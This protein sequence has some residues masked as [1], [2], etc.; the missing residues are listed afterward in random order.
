MGRQTRRSSSLTRII[1]EPDRL[2][3]SPGRAALIVGCEVLAAGQGRQSINRPMLQ[4]LDCEQPAVLGK[5]LG[6][7]LGCQNASP[8]PD[9][10]GTTFS[11]T[12]AKTP[13]ERPRD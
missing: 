7:L 10:C 2:R 1:H 4:T 12:L 11:I 9:G 13:I 8:G 5:R 6:E 3:N